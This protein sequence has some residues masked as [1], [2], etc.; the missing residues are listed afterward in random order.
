MDIFGDIVYRDGEIIDNSWIKWTHWGV[1]DEEGE[2]R[3]R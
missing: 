3:E 2:E 1:P